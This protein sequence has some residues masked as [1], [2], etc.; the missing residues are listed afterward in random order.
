MSLVSAILNSAAEMSQPVRR[1]R[2]G[3]MQA[4]PIN[5]EK[6]REYLMS[7]SLVKELLRLRKISL[8]LELAR[9]RRS[10]KVLSLW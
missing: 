9:V 6:L 5:R 3:N 2:S 7:I 10:K 8:V 4:H 1:W